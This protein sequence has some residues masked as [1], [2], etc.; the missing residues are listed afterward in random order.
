MIIQPAPLKPGE[1]VGIMCPAGFMPKE[2]ANACVEQLK[3]WGYA[4]VLG[5]TLSSTSTNYFSGTDQERAADL[6][7]QLDDDA[8]RLILFGRGGYG[9]SRI[10]DQLDFTRFV[11]NPK[12][13]AGYSDIT[14]LLAHLYTRYGISSLH[15]PMAGAFAD[16]P[17]DNVYLPSIRDLVSGR[18][19]DYT[20]LPDLRNKMGESV[21]PLLGG[22]LALFTHL[23]GTPSFP[24][25]TG[26]IL[27]L[28][29]VGE[30]LYNIDRMLRQ[31]K[32]SGQL[33]KIGGMIFG[34]F[35][36]CKDTDRPFGQEVSEIL[37]AIVEPYEIPV[38]YDFPVSHTGRNY[39]LKYGATVRLQ[40]T[41]AGVRLQETT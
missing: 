12:W 16:Y 24:D 19:M 3:A 39:A 14:V 38:C 2:R 33:E 20:L 32:R 5:E 8:I 27:F 17:G 28:E 15:A 9:M 25:M 34:G 26:A 29:D 13:I 30:Q 4:T 23:I 40:V 18:E 21:G 22:N 31:L 37:Q 11:N 6:Q 7:R 35:T 10:I 36:D 1:T 41:A